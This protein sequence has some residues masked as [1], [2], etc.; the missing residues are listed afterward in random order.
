MDWYCKA[1]GETDTRQV[2]RSA[3][4]REKYTPPKDETTARPPVAVLPNRTPCSDMHWIHR[5][6]SGGLF[7]LPKG[8]CSLFWPRQCVTPTRPFSCIDN[9]ARIHPYIFAFAEFGARAQTFA[10]CPSHRRPHAMRPLRPPWRP[11]HAYL[12]L[13][14]E[15]PTGGWGGGGFIVMPKRGGAAGSLLPW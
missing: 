5:Q 2:I 4:A 12:S 10:R 6:A 7:W 3:R 11:L 1:N 9:Q 8:P 15:T 14:S 13:E